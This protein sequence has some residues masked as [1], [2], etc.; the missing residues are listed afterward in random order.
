MNRLVF[1]LERYG[2]AL[3]AD[4]QERYGLNLGELWRRGAYRRLLNLV[5]QLPQASRFA[6]AVANDP[7]HVAAILEATGDQPA[8]TSPDMAEWTAQAE[9]LA[10]IRDLTTTQ[11]AVAV[12]ATGGKPSAIP[13]AR[14]PRTAFADV[15]DAQRAARHRSIV[16][17]VKPRP[18]RV[19]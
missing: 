7:E 13:A 4:F 18:A 15:R 9:L 11:I 17:R 19:E 1:Y 8:E 2:N 14:R 6:G 5:E 10:E 16:E 3:E 12:A